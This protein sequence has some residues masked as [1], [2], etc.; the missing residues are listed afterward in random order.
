MTRSA[1]LLTLLLHLRT[2]E[3]HTVATLAQ[4]FGVSRRTMLRDLQALSELGVPLSAIPGPHGGY[5]LLG[6]RYTPPLMVTAE[7]A[8]GLAI[9]YEAFNR[10]AALPLAHEG[11]SPMSRVLALLPT[12]LV[13]ELQQLQ[14]HIAII[15]HPRHY[16]A[17][18]LSALF[19]AALA[20]KHLAITYQSGSGCSERIIFPY[21]IY[22]SQGY[23]YCACYDYQRQQKL[24]LRAD[25][26][27]AVQPLADRSPL[28]PITL[29]DWFTLVET[30]N[31][32]SD[33]ALPLRARLTVRGA[34]RF[35]LAELSAAITRTESGG[36]LATTIPATE[37][38]YY[39]RIFV[40]LGQ[41][42]I[43]DEPPVL[44]AAMQDHARAVLQ[45]YPS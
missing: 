10:Y 11:R 36:T 24:S 6:E 8:L 33:T 27:Q 5:A 42:A 15:E 21:G 43:V 18:F 41:E 31:P 37:L 40:A 4:Q 28:P 25:R 30:I 13:A 32:D 9:A 23:W 3:R 16:A 44:I 19:Q 12:A 22:A 20:N 29:R 26:V 38:A 14:E 1:R 39:A 7:E 35:E 2:H 17:P 45:Q 34:Q